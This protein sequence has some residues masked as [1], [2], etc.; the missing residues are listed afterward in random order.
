MGQQKS[1]RFDDEEYI[2]GVVAFAVP[3]KTHR[4]DLQVAIW[5]VGLKHQ[6]SSGSIAEI[7][8]FLLNAAREI[9]LRF[10]PPILES[11][12]ENDSESRVASA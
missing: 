4:N 1:I 10:F 11:G 2:E 12:Y 6:V 3:I 8:K 7:S 5:A 9:N